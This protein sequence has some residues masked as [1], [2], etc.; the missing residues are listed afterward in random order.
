[1]SGAVVPGEPGRG[2]DEPRQT[3]PLF[4]T[5]LKFNITAG[6]PVLNRTRADGK[7]D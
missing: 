2:A 1:M 4:W 3:Q 6:I 7:K 5:P